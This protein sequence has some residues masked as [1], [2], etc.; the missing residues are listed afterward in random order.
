VSNVALLTAQVLEIGS[1]VLR[2]QHTHI[3]GQ[4]KQIIILAFHLH[5]IPR[6]RRSRVALYV[7]SSVRLHTVHLY[8][9]RLYSDNNCL[10]TLR[11]SVEWNIGRGLWLMSDLGRQQFWDTILTLPGV[12]EENHGSPQFGEWFIAE[13][14]S[15]SS[16]QPRVRWV[17]WV[18]VIIASMSSFSRVFCSLQCCV[19]FSLP[20]F[21]PHIMQFSWVHRLCKLWKYKYID[22]SSSLR[23][24]S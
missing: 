3:A 18:N 1:S 17:M 7:C 19:C 9:Y 23:N 12:T 20:P 21:V 5:P 8:Q 6:L 15:S 11:S 10:I 16:A 13:N 22:C 14:E 24:F 2:A 4:Y